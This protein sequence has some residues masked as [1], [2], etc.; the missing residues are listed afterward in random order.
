MAVERLAAILPGQARVD[1]TGASAPEAGGQT[2]TIEVQAA[3]LRPLLAWLGVS[4]ADLPPGGLTTL[5]LRAAIGVLK[6]PVGAADRQLPAGL[7][8]DGATEIL[9][10]LNPGETV[11]TDNNRL[12]VDGQPVRI[13]P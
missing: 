8:H 10:G 7:R 1:W 3:E 13:K 9:T 11:A 4:E 5:D 2:G 12:L 6:E